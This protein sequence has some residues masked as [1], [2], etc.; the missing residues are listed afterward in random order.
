[1]LAEPPK[2]SFEQI[3]DCLSPRK[4][5]ISN[6]LNA[7]QVEKSVTYITFG[8]DRKRY[9]K[10]DTKNWL[11]ALIYSAS[12]LTKL[13]NMLS[14]VLEYRSDSSAKEFNDSI[15]EILNFQTYLSHKIEEAIKEW[16]SR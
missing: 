12:N 13:N 2:I 1:M 7:L 15:G 10:G 3:K 6:A 16:Q 11:H 4:S 8:G 5:A 14:D 9:F